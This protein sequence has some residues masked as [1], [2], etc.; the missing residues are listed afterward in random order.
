MPKK[1]EIE[2]KKNS[3]SIQQKRAQLELICH[4]QNKNV[5]SQKQKNIKKNIII[6]NMNISK[7]YF[8]ILILIDIIAQIFLTNKLFFG[9][10]NYSFITLKI[11]G[12]GYR[13]LFCNNTEKFMTAYYPDEIY[14]N[15]EMQESINYSYYFNQAYN[16]VKLGWHKNIDNMGYMFNGC[17][18]IKEIDLSNF[19]TSEATDMRCMFADCK[20]ITSL[21]LSNFDTSKVTVMFNM[22][23][24]CESLTSLDLS[25]L[26]TSLIKSM[27]DVFK[28]CKSLSSL[29]LSS[30]NTINLKALAFTFSGCIN[31]EYINFS[32][33]IVDSLGWRDNMYQNVPKNIV[34]CVNEQNG[35]KLI[36]KLTDLNCIVEDCSNDWKSKQKKINNSNNKCFDTCGYNQKEY[37]SKCY[38][39]C[40]SGILIYNNISKTYECK[41][42]LE[43]CLTC[44]PVA[45][46][47]NLCT[48]CNNNYYEIE[49]DENNI[50]EY[51]NCYKDPKGYYLD[52]NASLYKKCYYKCET[53]DIKGDE[54]N[55]NC[56]SCSNNFPVGI[57]FNDINNYKMCYKKCNN[58][59]LYDCDENYRCII[60]S[61][62]PN[63]YSYE[64]KDL[65]FHKGY[66]CIE[67]V[68]ENYYLD[69]N[70][71][72]Y[73]EC[74]MTCK[75]CSKQGNKTINNCDKCIDN[76]IFLNIS[77][78][79][80]QNCYQKCDYYFYFN[81]N[82]EYIC[83]NSKL[84]PI[85]YNKLVEEKNK[86]ID[87]CKNDEE[88][89]YEYNNKCFKKCPNNL[90]I[91]EE[92][93]KCLESCY[94]YQFEYNNI[95]Y[96]DC[97]ND[98]YRI[99][100]NRNICLEEIPENYHLDNNDDIYK[101]C[102]KTCKTC[103]KQ[104]NKT[105]N[106]CD[107]CKE[108]FIS[109]QESIASLQSYYPYS[110]NNL[111]INN[112]YHCSPNCSEDKP[113]EIIDIQ[114]CVN[115]CTIDDFKN[116]LCIINY[117]KENLNNGLNN[118]IN[119]K[120]VKI[121][122]KALALIEEE[123]ISEKYDKSILEKGEDIIIDI[124]NIITTL[125]TTQNQKNSTNN[126]STR[127]DLGECENL[128]RKEYNISEK[129]VIY[130]RKIDIFKLWMETPEVDFDLYIKLNE[131]NLVKLN[132]S[133]CENSEIYVLIP[134]NISENIDIYNI[135]SGYYNDI[136]YVSKS[137]KGTD[138]ILKDRRQEYIDNNMTICQG[139]C[140]FSEYNYTTQI[141]NC[142][143]KVNQ[144]STSSKL[145]GD[146]DIN[147]MFNKF[148]DIKNIANLNILSCY[149]IL[150]TRKGI[151][152]N[153][154]ALS[155]IIIFIIHFIFIIFYFIQNFIKI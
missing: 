46:M 67:N 6:R 38:D 128:L 94:E 88:Y 9:K 61:S 100:Q 59:Y 91:F 27:Q 84:C 153:I 129:E 139:D 145:K 146:I 4:L 143:C 102:Y 5:K 125:T 135:S 53:C 89:I 155:I 23:S 45:L 36:D 85:Q 118:N 65:I 3:F 147:K 142:S 122:N 81:K 57:N 136:C 101:E 110:I 22:F 133:I 149:K 2:T 7:H 79:P 77:F 15:A 34:I 95:C 80:S 120:L 55:H 108:G 54:E 73:K 150:F 24:N 74:Y 25:S 97:P 127:I 152:N 83:T 109:I 12:T 58:Y 17:S 8:F 105:N 42:E 50:G 11:N 33:F 26:N 51:I 52:K 78:V 130:M 103:S 43:Q 144:L 119:D 131:T 148:K 68:P 40:P 18:D 132:L 47:H 99:Y 87:E 63:E 114:E 117:G 39:N 48:K 137:K 69:N 96:V 141:V 35:A 124:E 37:N 66:R 111:D 106:N 21:N 113:F 76:Y 70:D 41:C 112:I 14:I 134:Y 138:I 62:Y 29:D 20:S 98:T 115:N 116:K 30:F 49:N 10:E 19:N 123:F 140:D 16:Y 90:K 1:Q 56:L 60:N 31:L 151:S 71:N 72:I 86:C 93:K 75:T 121:M 28:N 104:G 64:I 13:Q 92:D 44:P 32:S 107:E 154:G 82:N 126:N